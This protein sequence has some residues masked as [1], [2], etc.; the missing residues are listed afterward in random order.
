ME[1]DR[2]AVKQPFPRY[3]GETA[4]EA[5]TSRETLCAALCAQCAR[6]V[7]GWLRPELTETDFALWKDALAELAGGRG[8]L[9]AAACRGGGDAPKP[10]GGE[11]EAGGRLQQPE[12]PAAGRGKAAGR[13]SGAGGDGLLFWQNGKGGG[14]WPSGVR[15]GFAGRDG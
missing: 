13:V 14:Q 3:S 15:T 4:D 8:L 10:D 6:Q 9:S 2:T 7:E 11:P 5:G 12:G 1:L